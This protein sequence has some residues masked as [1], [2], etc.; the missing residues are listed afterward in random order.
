MN[1]NE[2]VHRK[3]ESWE[4]YRELLELVERKNYRALTPAEIEEFALLYRGISADLAAART[5]FPRTEL[6]HELNGLV[7]R[8]Y[9]WLY[10]SGGK[11]SLSRLLHF[12]ARGY[13]KLIAENIRPLAW[14]VALFIFFTVVGV[15]AYSVDRRIADTMVPKSMV[16]YFQQDLETKGKAERDIPFVQRSAFSSQLMVNNIQVSFIAFAGGILFGLG[17]LFIS[18]K[19]ALMVGV[20]GQVFAEHGSLINY[21]GFILPHGVIELSAII[22]S[23]AAGFIMG[24]S[25]INPGGMTRGD[26]L[27]R[28]AL[29]AV[30]I[31]FGVVPM[32]IIAG[33]IEAFFTPIKWIPDTIKVIFSCVLFALLLLYLMSG[34]IRSKKVRL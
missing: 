9:A 3:K 16:K 26:S 25:L 27:R 8:G 31:M 10:T 20:L 5:N 18:I 34:F 22:L 4:R 2:F 7:S 32:L 33:A 28:A 12:F 21:L 14:T 17:T 11:S 19:N 29:T 1:I 30:N 23:T 24:F 15:A 13:P 6:T